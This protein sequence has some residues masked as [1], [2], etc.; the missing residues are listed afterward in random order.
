MYV[1]S[2]DTINQLNRFTVNS[3]EEYYRSYSELGTRLAD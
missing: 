2:I 3:R 1:L